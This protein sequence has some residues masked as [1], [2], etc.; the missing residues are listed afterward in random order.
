MV[1]QVQVQ[2]VG[3]VATFVYYSS[4]KLFALETCR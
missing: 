1:S 4:S 2:I 3:I